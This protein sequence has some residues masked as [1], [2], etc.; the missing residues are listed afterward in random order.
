MTFHYSS[1]ND[2][3]IN[4][5]S[6]GPIQCSFCLSL[7]QT[8]NKQ[9]K[10]SWMDCVNPQ[11]RVQCTNY[12]LQKDVWVIGRPRTLWKPCIPDSTLCSLWVL[13]LSC[14]MPWFILRIYW[15]NN[16]GIKILTWSHFTMVQV[17]FIVS[18][19]TSLSWMNWLAAKILN[20]RCKYVMDITVWKDMLQTC[21][22]GLLF[23]Y[24]WE[25]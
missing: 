11:S 14:T 24:W 22:E 19:D 9:S 17:L 8:L 16:K 21:W 2:I 1:Y 10:A 5:Y 15:N 6:D 12:W 25:D 18:G 4:G 20:I 3:P 7:P 13:R 23:F